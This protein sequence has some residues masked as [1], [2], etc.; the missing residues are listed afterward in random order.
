MTFERVPVP[1]SAVDCE[2]LVRLQQRGVP[3]HVREHHRNKATIER[4][5]HDA[6]LS[7]PVRPRQTPFAG[8]SRKPSNGL[9]PLTPSLPCA[10][11]RL[12]WV[13]TGCG[14]ACLS[15][16]SGS[17]ICHPLPLVAPVGLLTGAVAG[18]ATIT[19]AAGFVPIYASVVIGI[20]AGAVCYF[21]IQLKNRLR[22]DDALDVWG[23]HGIGGLLG[24]VLLGVFASRAINRRAGPA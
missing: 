4:V 5:N 3:G 8:I 22:W 10:P 24:I 14:S 18:L 23:V 9:E 20:V 19:P 15:G 2:T 11:E 7:A 21:A 6:I 17:P 12:P 16:F 1:L 13:A